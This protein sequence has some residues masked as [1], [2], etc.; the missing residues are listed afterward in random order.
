VLDGGSTDG[1]KEYLKTSP[2]CVTYWRSYQDRGQSHALNEGFVKA[3]GD[4][5]GWQ[6]SDDFYY[7]GTFWTVAKIARIYPQAGVI[8]GDT[9]IVDQYGVV[10]TLIGI[11]PVPA[12]LWLRGYWPYNQAVFIRH[13]L[14]LKVCQL[15]N[16][17]ISTWIRYA[18]ENC[19]ISTACRLRE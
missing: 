13:E 6:N 12:R 11:S 9:A 7:P 1:T 8:V 4:W 2:G 5:I 3:S 16:H 15:M 17:S 19:V 10:R 18:G 14:V